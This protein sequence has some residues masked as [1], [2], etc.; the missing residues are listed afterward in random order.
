MRDGFLRSLGLT[1]EEE[2]VRE[3]Y[4]KLLSN[5][6]RPGLLHPGLL[7]RSQLGDSV[8]EDNIEVQE[9]LEND[10]ELQVQGRESLIDEEIQPNLLN[11][12]PYQ[13]NLNRDSAKNCC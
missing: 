10:Y 12:P 11:V 3:F 2:E 1:R 6:K 8:R 4:R 9:G 5:Q 7:L 13:P